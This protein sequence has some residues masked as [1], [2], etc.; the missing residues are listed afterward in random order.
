MSGIKNIFCP[1]TG[2]GR[3][4][5]FK[6]AVKNRFR[7]WKGKITI[8]EGLAQTFAKPKDNAFNPGD[9]V[10]LRY[11]KRAERLPGFLPQN[12][13]AVVFLNGG[14]EGFVRTERFAD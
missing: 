13:N 3:H 11:D 7:G 4:Q 8:P 10:V 1:E 2:T 14:F 5:A 9:I 12:A 6:T